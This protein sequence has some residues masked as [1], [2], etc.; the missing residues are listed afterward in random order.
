MRGRYA[1]AAEA[2]LAGASGQLRNVATAGGSFSF[3]FTVPAGQKSVKGTITV[4]GEDGS[5]TVYRWELT[6]QN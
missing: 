2:L 6:R 5:V 3:S 1:A 4:N